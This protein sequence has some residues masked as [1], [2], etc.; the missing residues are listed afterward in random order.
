MSLQRI[1][2]EKIDKQATMEKHVEDYL[3]VLKDSTKSVKMFSA[4]C[5]SYGRA[6]ILKLIEESPGR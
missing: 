1:N 6:K 5:R 4:L 3:R 2:Q